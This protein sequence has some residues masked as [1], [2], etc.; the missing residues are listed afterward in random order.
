MKSAFM[1]KLI[2]EFG[3]Y[4][5]KNKEEYKYFE[6]NTAC[7]ESEELFI[8]YANDFMKELLTSIGFEYSDLEKLD[9]VSDFAY[10]VD[11][12]LWNWLD[13]R[14]LNEE[15]IKILIAAD[16]INGNEYFKRE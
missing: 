12:M 6:V 11:N 9:L 3:E 10:C 5:E 16:Y 1:E 2:R 15:T 13:N 7:T 14:K 8:A 4:K